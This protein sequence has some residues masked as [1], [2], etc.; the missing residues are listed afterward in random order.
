MSEHGFYNPVD[1]YWQTCDDV[2]T[3]ILKAYPEGTVEVPLKPGAGYEFSGVEW[4]RK[5]PTIVDLR[6]SKAAAIVTKADTLLTVGA[7]ADSGL[8]VALDERSLSDLAIMSGIATAAASGAVVWPDSYVRGWITVENVRIPLATP[9]AGLA[10]AA[11]VGN[12]YA[13]IVQHRRDLKDATLAAGDATVLEAIDIT[14]GWP[15]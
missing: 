9:I 12:Y 4:I 3:E 1:G 15:A 8:H 11:S 2:P 14:T 6:A 10:L 7:P 5:P 13:A